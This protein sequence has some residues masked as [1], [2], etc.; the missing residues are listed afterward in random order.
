MKIQNTPLSQ[1]E[2]EISA[3]QAEA[4]RSTAEGEFVVILEDKKR[5]TSEINIIEENIKIGKKN[6]DYNLEKIN[7][8]NQSI[9][10]IQSSLRKEKQ[11][12]DEFIKESNNKKDTIQGEIDKKN[13]EKEEIVFEIV[14]LSKQHETDKF[15][16]SQEIKTLEAT[17]KS[18]NTEIGKFNEEKSKIIKD[19][20]GYEKIFSDLAKQ[21][22]ELLHKKKTIESTITSLLNE[23]ENQ[24]GVIVNNKV[25]LNQQ[26]DKKKEKETEISKLDEKIIIKEKEYK[27]IESKAF[28]IL[29]KQ[30]L[31][32]NK[33]AFIKG[34]Y[35]RAGIKW[36]E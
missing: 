27:E 23:I 33:T 21:E 14:S 17:Y 26:D 8:L 31:L 18:L 4:R 20:Y 9:L 22:E 3:Q 29:N 1:T 19:I 16:K 15:G 24:K 13:K 35:E 5:I 28:S 12:L 6:I 32:D 7:T 34:Q 30:Q 25:I 10:D 2:Q 36:E 11:G